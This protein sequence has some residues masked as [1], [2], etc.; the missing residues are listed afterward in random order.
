MRT[1]ESMG[2]FIA[3]SESLSHHPPDEHPHAVD[4]YKVALGQNAIK[5]VEA[6]STIIPLLPLASTSTSESKDSATPAGASPLVRTRSKQIQPPTIAEA[7]LLWW[8]AATS[9]H[10]ARSGLPE[11]PFAS[12][13]ASSSKLASGSSTRKPRRNTPA[14]TMKSDLANLRMVKSLHRRMARLKGKNREM[15]EESDFSASDDDLDNDGS[16]DDSPATLDDAKSGEG[17]LKTAPEQISRKRKR[18]K[19]RLD[20]L[21]PPPDIQD[22]PFSARANQQL[23]SAFCGILLQQTGFDGEDYLRSLLPTTIF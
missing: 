15:P 10:F 12:G 23:L 19:P 3:L 11:V 5:D 7:D 17:E 21:D 13:D 18:P 16:A 4:A 1:S 6:T 2:R 14:S 9:E 8:Q 20:L 22:R